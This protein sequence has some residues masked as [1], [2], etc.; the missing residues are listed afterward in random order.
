M[1]KP[2]LLREILAKLEAELATLV[3]AA[4]EAKS[5]A[6][7]AESKQE[8]KYDMR[9]QSAAYLAA[10]QARLAAEV[11]Q[12][13]AAYRA[14]SLAAPAPGAPLGAGAVVTV[15]S[16]ARPVRYFLGP[17]R[18]GL[19]VTVDGVAV[20]VITAASPIGGKIFG[21]RL[22]DSVSLPGD[23]TSGAIVGAE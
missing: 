4:N 3:A 5:E 14:L 7:D 17:S 1:D 19:E 23:R 9:G 15:L 12:A 10:G 22:G 2:A 13:I 8:G 20:T 18:G 11:Q 21:R 6:T 16:A